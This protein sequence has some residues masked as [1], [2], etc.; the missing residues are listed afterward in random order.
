MLNTPEKLFSDNEHD[1][2]AHRLIIESLSD[3][4]KQLDYANSFQLSAFMPLVT[5][6]RMMLPGNTLEQ[7]GLYLR[8]L[9]HCC[10]V[11]GKLDTSFYESV[12]FETSAHTIS[13]I[14][15]LLGWYETTI[16]R[17]LHFSKGQAVKL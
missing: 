10:R 11:M 9:A 3:I 17:C 15:R 8:Q 2:K 6:S 12:L 4:L 5:I 13:R 14:G 16:I 1:S 7:G